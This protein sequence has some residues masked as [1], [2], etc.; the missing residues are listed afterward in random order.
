MS[1]TGTTLDSSAP[2]V[3]FAT[4]TSTDLSA[5]NISIPAEP[6]VF[7]IDPI[8]TTLENFKNAFYTLGSDNRHSNDLNYFKPNLGIILDQRI[9][10]IVKNLLVIGA[11]G[12]K[13]ASGND[14]PI[15]Y[16]TRNNNTSTFNLNPIIIDEIELASE[17]PYSTWSSDSQIN[18]L[19]K[20]ASVGFIYGISLDLITSGNPAGNTNALTWT[21]LVTITNLTLYNYLTLNNGI[22]P[23]EGQNVVV[24]LN[25]IVRFAYMVYTSQESQGGNVVAK[26]VKTDFMFQYKITDWK[27]S[28]N[29]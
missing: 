5:I 22:P 4:V 18:L 6:R 3:I 27:F 19:R 8:E 28:Y 23:V 14:L 17:Q 10:D 2:S 21:D 12:G 9:I 29:G 24:H 1:N 7:H 25:Y 20:L 16:I 15:K 11:G 13:D 26:E